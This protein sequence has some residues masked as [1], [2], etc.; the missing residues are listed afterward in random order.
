MYPLDL[1]FLYVKGDFNISFILKFNKVNLCTVTLKNDGDSTTT[2]SLLR[3]PTNERTCWGRYRGHSP[4][5]IVGQGDDS[6]GS[7]TLEL[8]VQVPGPGSLLSTDGGL[9][10]S[11][12]ERGRRLRVSKRLDVSRKRK[13][14]PL[15]YYLGAPTFIL[16][17]CVPVGNPPSFIVT[18]L[19]SG[20][21]PLV[22]RVI[23]GW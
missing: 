23:P 17:V 8:P 11:P 21:G 1:T 19:D 12:Q 5:G 14:N 15:F 13:R 9:Y 18:L 22:L 4:K 7:G 20:S 16:R 3:P 2:P 10:S 6:F